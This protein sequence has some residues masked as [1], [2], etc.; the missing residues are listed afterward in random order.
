M[1]SR[2][3]RNLLCDENCILGDCVPDPGE[4]IFQLPDHRK[5]QRLSDV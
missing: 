2:S 5:P 4:R 1:E 3:G